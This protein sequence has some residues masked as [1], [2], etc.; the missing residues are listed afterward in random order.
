MPPDKQGRSQQLPE[1]ETR[2]LRRWIKRVR[3]GLSVV[4]W[5]TLKAPMICVQGG[6]GG[7]FNRRSSINAGDG[8]KHQNP[9]SHRR[10]HW[11]SAPNMGSSRLPVL[12]AEL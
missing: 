9:Q 5:I 6:I 7:R 1:N 12:I 4:F 3:N 11:Q 2:M 8:G 10:F